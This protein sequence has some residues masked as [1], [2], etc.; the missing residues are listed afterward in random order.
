VIGAVVAELVRRHGG[1]ALVVV[2]VGIIVWAVMVRPSLGAAVALFSL[3]LV[4]AVSHA[5]GFD[6]FDKEDEL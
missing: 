2:A 6:L 3:W 4:L 5:L 1:K